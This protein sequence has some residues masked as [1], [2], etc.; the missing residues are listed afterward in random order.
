VLLQRRK[1]AAA[2]LFQ[3]QSNAKASAGIRPAG[4]DAENRWGRLE[5]WGVI[6]AKLYQ[7]I[8]DFA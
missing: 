3:R 5:F 2:G 4:R 1:S 7:F 6:C 8:E